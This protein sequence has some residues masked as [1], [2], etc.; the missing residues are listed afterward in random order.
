MC[1]AIAPRLGPRVAF[2]AVA[3]EVGFANCLR[4]SSMP[5]AIRLII[6]CAVKLVTIGLQNPPPSLIVADHKSLTGVTLSNQNTAFVCIVIDI[7]DVCDW[8]IEL[9]EVFQSGGIAAN[10]NVLGYPMSTLGNPP[11]DTPECF[12]GGRKPKED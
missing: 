3:F 8:E 2:D 5:R 10:D 11:C 4:V 9:L 1:F 7:G 12:F 6:S